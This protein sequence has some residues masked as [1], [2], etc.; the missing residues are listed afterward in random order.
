MAEQPKCEELINDRLKQVLD[1]DLPEWDNMD[2]EDV[3]YWCEALGVDATDFTDEHAL[4]D[5]L[6]EKHRDHILEGVLSVEK[7]RLY[8]VCLSWG[9]PSDGFDFVF[10]NDELTECY[11]WYKDWFDGAR[12]PVPMDQ[13]EQLVDLY[14]V[15]PQ[16]E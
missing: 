11:Y 9:G 14:C 12:R 5:E 1:N 13:A 15:G 8:S 6:R 4:V 7:K 3:A 16:F 2:T 10:E